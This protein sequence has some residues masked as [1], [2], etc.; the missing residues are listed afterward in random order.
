MKQLP[1]ASEEA[2]VPR[3]RQGPPSRVGA[4]SCSY[5]RI[6]VLDQLGCVLRNVF[7]VLELQLD[8]FHN[9]NKVLA[10]GDL[11]QCGI[12]VPLHIF[13]RPS[14]IPTDGRIAYVA[15]ADMHAVLH[16]GETRS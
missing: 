14:S 9:V 13:Q 2:L 5:A 15:S 12:L 11:Y 1:Q 6:E 3:H 7:L 16:R 10:L 4:A 8:V